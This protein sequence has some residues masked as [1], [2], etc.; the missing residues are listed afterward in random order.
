MSG[1]ILEL[2]E[3]ASTAQPSKYERSGTA[4]C[5]SQDIVRRDVQPEAFLR[6]ARLHAMRGLRVPSTM[7]A[8]RR[9]STATY[10]AL[11]KLVRGAGAI[12]NAISSRRRAALNGA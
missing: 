9:T 11:L 7:A 4:I 8:R 3:P 6:D 12:V 1:F 10:V 2:E 5:A